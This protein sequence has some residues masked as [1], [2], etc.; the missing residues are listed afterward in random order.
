MTVT[1]G[2]IGTLTR[3]SQFWYGTLYQIPSIVYIK[4]KLIY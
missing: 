4:N 3:F 1:L 2:Q